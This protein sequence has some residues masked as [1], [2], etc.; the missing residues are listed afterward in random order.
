V[1]L[2]YAQVV[3]RLRWLIDPVELQL[4]RMPDGASV[5]VETIRQ[6]GTRRLPT[7]DETMLVI[8]ALTALGILSGGLNR[9]ILN[10]AILLSTEMYR[11]GIRDGLKVRAVDYGSARL[12]VALPPGLNQ[13]VSMAFQEVTEDLRGAIIDLVAGAEQDLVLISPF[14]DAPTLNELS[15]FLFRRLA[16]GVS[17]RLLGR[18]DNRTPNAI[19][20]FLL[21]L[22]AYEQCQ[23]LSWY[24]TSAIDPF[25]AS[26]FHLKAAV[27]DGNRGYLGTA[28]FTVAGLRSRL[29][30]GILL[31]GQAAERLAAVTDAV[32]SLARPVTWPVNHE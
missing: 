12:C 22:R 28:N 6:C 10:R 8:D 14:W 7:L 1:T 13:S 24:E 21:R 30:L 3:D 26:T 16:V 19:K 20:E 27:A 29:E 4:F 23:V 2:Q 18:F 9:Y 5:S 17:L 32:L 11:K 31:Q 15:P 25:G